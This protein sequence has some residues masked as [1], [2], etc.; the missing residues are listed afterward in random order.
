MNLAQNTEVVLSPIK[1]V[2]CWC[3]YIIGNELA[4][5]TFQPGI[6]LP[7]SPRSRAVPLNSASGTH[8]RRGDSQHRAG[9]HR[10]STAATSHSRNYATDSL[11][12]GV[13][14]TRP[15]FALHGILAASPQSLMARP[16]VG[17]AFIALADDERA[18][19]FYDLDRLA[20][21]WSEFKA[22]RTGDVTW[23]QPKM[24]VSVKHLAAARCSGT[25]LLER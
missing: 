20:V 2:F 17:T 6:T 15:S 1:S 18:R 22:S 23:C 7:F 16:I 25:R 4:H 14:G 13:T 12:T 10:R 9:S 11:A 5:P 21:S 19:F 3:R 8:N 24:A